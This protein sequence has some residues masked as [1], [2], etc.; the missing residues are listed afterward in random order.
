MTK[1]EE[2]RIIEQ[3]RKAYPS[4]PVGILTVPDPPYPDFVLTTADHRRIGIEVTE[5]FHSEEKKQYSSL[6][7]QVTDKLI[8]E[9]K[10]RLPYKFTMNVFPDRNRAV[11]KARIN[12]LIAE[13]ADLC[14]AEFGTLPNN[15]WGEVEH[16]EYDL[17]TMEPGP[18]RRVLDQGYRNL[19]SGI[20]CIRI[21]RYDGLNESR[22]SHSEGGIVPSLTLEHVVPILLKK[23]KR[24][25]SQ[26][27]LDENWLLIREG[28]FYTGTFDEV[29]LPLPISS[30]FSKVFLFRTSADEVIELKG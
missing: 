5:V 21:H 26:P 8:E 11:R 7:D 20:G 13:L 23:E 2:H 12:E 14:V 24:L 10:K 28:N 1:K 25:A 17:N 9:L 27:V 6:K 15:D 16:I 22:N 29:R 19:P 4:F 3:F 18:L 30:T